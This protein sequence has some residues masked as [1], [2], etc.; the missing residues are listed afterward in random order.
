MAGPDNRLDRD[1]GIVRVVPE[2][3]NGERREFTIRIKFIKCERESLDGEVFEHTQP[4]IE[5]EG[6]EEHDMYR[7]GPSGTCWSEDDVVD[8]VEISETDLSEYDPFNNNE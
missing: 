2:A 8:E 4:L 1:D 7:F 5:V 6:Y 3:R